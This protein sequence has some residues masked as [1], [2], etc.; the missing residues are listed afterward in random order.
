MMH[1]C[2]TSQKTFRDVGVHEVAHRARRH[3][4]R[5]RVFLEIHLLDRLTV[6][7]VRASLSADGSRMLLR[8]VFFARWQD[9]RPRDVSR[10]LARPGKAQAHLRAAALL[11]AMNA[12]EKTQGFVGL[13]SSVSQVQSN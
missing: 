10:R 5:D 6:S 11:D 1:E 7:F 4:K 13:P 9:G 3:E 8:N 2:C 12:L